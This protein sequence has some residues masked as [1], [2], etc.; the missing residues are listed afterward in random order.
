[1]SRRWNVAVNFLWAATERFVSSN[2]SRAGRRSGPL[3]TDFLPFNS[4]NGNR[5]FF[6]RTD[7]SRSISFLRWMNRH[8]LLEWRWTEGGIA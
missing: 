5:F 1:M 2:D 6:D 4:H 8:R 7:I 3:I